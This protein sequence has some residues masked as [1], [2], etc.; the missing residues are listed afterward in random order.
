MLGNIYY[1]SVAKGANASITEGLAEI[2]NKVDNVS[3]AVDNMT[4]AFN[5]SIT[6]GRQRVEVLGATVKSV[7]FTAGSAS[8]NYVFTSTC[9]RAT[10]T[11]TTADILVKI[12]AGAQT[13]TSTQ[14]V[15]YGAVIPA[16]QSKDFAFPPGSQIAYMRRGVTDAAIDITELN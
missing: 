6:Q 10:I 4:N 5:A 9:T 13:V 11:A 8:A 3:G 7:A 2:A 15:N 14:G 12:G 1:G 16:G